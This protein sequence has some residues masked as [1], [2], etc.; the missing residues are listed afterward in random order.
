MLK[1][2]LILLMLL[3]SPAIFAQDANTEQNPQNNEE[4]AAKPHRKPVKYTFQSDMAIDNQTV[5]SLHKNSL[6][7]MI[8]HRFGVIDNSTDLYGIF[9]PSNIRIGLNYGITKRLAIGIGATKNKNLYDLEWKYAILKQTRHGGIPVSISYYGNVDR[10]S[11][12]KSFF[13]IKD[14]A[15]PDTTKYESY[16]RFSFFHEIMIARKIND[17]IGLQLAGTWSHVNLVDSGMQHDIIGV[18]FA[19]KYQFSAQSAILLEFDYPLVTHDVNKNM[20]NL[21][22]AYEVS[23][24]GHTFQIILCTADG[25]NNEEIMTYNTNDFSKKQILLGFNISRLWDF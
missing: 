6:E 22:I 16:D 14:D 3:I 15:R 19:G 2:K 7:F 9:G 18:S 5:E 13:Q 8:Q 25:I 20:P 23:T 12:S 24:G 17:H 4:T 10:S 11:A 1:H 21:G